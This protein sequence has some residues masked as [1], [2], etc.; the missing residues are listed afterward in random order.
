MFFLFIELT[1]VFIVRIFILQK[2]K[3]LSSPKS[4]TNLEKEI[5]NYFLNFYNKL[6]T[7][8]DNLLKELQSLKGKGVGLGRVNAT[9]RTSTDDLQKLLYCTE[10]ISS[11]KYNSKRLL[12]RLRQIDEIPCHLLTTNGGSDLI[13][14]VM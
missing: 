6:Q 9:I 11:K 3:K 14:Y 13:K 10:K 8:E 2:I 5:S 7:I 4:T 12:E 1:V